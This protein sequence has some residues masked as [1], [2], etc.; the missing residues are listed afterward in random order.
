MRATEFGHLWFIDH[1][2]ITYKG[3]AYVVLV[4]LDAASNLLIVQTQTDKKEHTTMEAL[5]WHGQYG[6]CDRAISVQTII[7]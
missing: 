3:Y 1:V 2:D 7:S 5:K 4:I 6:T